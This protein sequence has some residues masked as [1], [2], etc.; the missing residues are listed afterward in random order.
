LGHLGAGDHF[1]FVA[2]KNEDFLTWFRLEA[3]L[4]ARLGLLPSLWFSYS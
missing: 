4:G 1:G 3:L 2:I